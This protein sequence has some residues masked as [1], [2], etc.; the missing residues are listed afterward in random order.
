MLNKA[1]SGGTNGKAKLGYVNTTVSI[2]GHRV[3]TIAVDDER[4]KFVVMAFELMASG[5]YANAEQVRDRLS[6]A[7]L[8]MPGNARPISMQTMHKLL[9]DKYYMGVVT[10]KDMEYPGHH[11]PLIAP[12][13]FSR[14]QRIMDSHQGASDQ[15]NLPTFDH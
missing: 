9:R 13:L 4:A 10:Y 5:R 6:D 11:E 7:G 1:R 8:T 2:D 12:E 15:R 14:V 3:N